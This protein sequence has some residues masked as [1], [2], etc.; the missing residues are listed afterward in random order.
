VYISVSIKMMNTETE[1]KS[2]LLQLLQ[3]YVWEVNAF[4]F[5]LVC[6]LWCFIGIIKLPLRTGRKI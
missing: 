5:M 6:L 4:A 3:L 2:C 1:V